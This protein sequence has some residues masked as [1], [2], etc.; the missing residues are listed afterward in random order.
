MLG[1]GN[2][3]MSSNAASNMS[4]RLPVDGNYAYLT[5]FGL[6]ANAQVSPVILHSPTELEFDDTVLEQWGYESGNLESVYEDIYFAQDSA[7]PLL[8]GDTITLSG[9]IRQR[10]IDANIDE[11]NKNGYLLF[12]FNVNTS[13]DAYIYVDEEFNGDV[14]GSHK[15]KVLADG[16]FTVTYA[17]VADTSKLVIMASSIMHANDN[18]EFDS[19]GIRVSNLS[20]TK[21]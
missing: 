9:K 4:K 15:Y 8:S 11:T 14:S 2:S 7:V 3:L 20:L 18:S 10:D 1:L 13:D 5:Q 21:D 12:K 19:I 6:G 16:T 17:L